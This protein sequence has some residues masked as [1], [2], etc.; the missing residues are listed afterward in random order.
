MFISSI[1]DC[2]HP[3]LVF[4]DL[5][6]D[7]IFAREKNLVNF[8]NLRVKYFLRDPKKLILRPLSSDVLSCGQLFTQ[9]V[10]IA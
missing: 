7:I 5:K 8:A 3:E 4:V 2:T 1:D 9:D 6:E 10:K